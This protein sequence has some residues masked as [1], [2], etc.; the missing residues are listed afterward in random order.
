[1]V[2][3]PRRRES[4][5]PH[6]ERPPGVDE[7]IWFLLALTGSL[8][9]FTSCILTNP[10][11]FTVIGCLIAFYAIAQGIIHDIHNPGKGKQK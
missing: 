3:V 6:Q 7:M 10:N 5:H 2:T 11:G 8:I 1:M 4:G 9:T